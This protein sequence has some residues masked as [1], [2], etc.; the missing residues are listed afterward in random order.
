MASNRISQGKEP[1]GRYASRFY[2]SHPPA[3]ISCLTRHEQGIIEAIERGLSNKEIAGE[4]G[5]HGTVFPKGATASDGDAIARQIG[6]QNHSN[7][8]ELLNTCCGN[9]K[10]ALREVLRCPKGRR[11]TAGHLL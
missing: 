9:F 11:W 7:Y 8:H 1:G 3:A 5:P 4:L 10:L 2:D 6:L